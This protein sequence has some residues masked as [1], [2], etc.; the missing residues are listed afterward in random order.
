MIFQYNIKI[1][2][3]YNT[4]AIKS[5]TES[6][7]HYEIQDLCEVKYSIEIN[8]RIGL[9]YIEGYKFV[10]TLKIKIHPNGNNN[11]TFGSCKM[12]EY[13]VNWMVFWRKMK[14]MQRNFQKVL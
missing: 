13:Y 3:T 5:N 9:D 6:E 8:K 1:P 11:N 10:D 14:Y 2:L 7:L 12:K 4:H